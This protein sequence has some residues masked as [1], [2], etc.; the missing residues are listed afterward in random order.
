MP[1][2]E[3]K[4][5]GTGLLPVV[6]ALKTIPEG[7]ERVPR[8]LRHYLEQRV[9]PSAWYPERDYNVLLEALAGSVDPRALSGE[10]VWKYFGRVAAQ[11]DL[12]GAEDE[13][14]RR[15]R[16]NAAGAYHRFL[17]G[18]SGNP[19]VFFSRL[20]KIW[21]LYHDTGRLE[22][23]RRR[24]SPKVAIMRL[25]GFKVPSVG[26]SDL[27]TAYFAE[28]ARLAGL[29]LTI[30]L[31]RSTARNDAFCEWELTIDRAPGLDQWLAS[32]PEA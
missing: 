32:L 23:L 12:A 1:A 9:L 25:I 19:G 31:L 26:Q 5:K 20:A 2:G 4:H 29:G 28:F 7:R 30:R 18:E 3:P 17:E 14:P 6:E 15:S 27:Q 16:T 24:G 10:D 11:R 8:E 21:H 13:I 22:F